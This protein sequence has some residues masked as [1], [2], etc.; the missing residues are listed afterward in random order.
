[1]N[2]DQVDTGTGRSRRNS[3]RSED[4]ADHGDVREDNFYAT[5]E[6]EAAALEGSSRGKNEND[7][8]QE[9]VVIGNVG[10]SSAEGA[11]GESPPSNVQQ[12]RIHSSS[13]SSGNSS[14]AVESSGG[15]EPFRDNNRNSVEEGAEDPSS[16]R[17]PSPFTA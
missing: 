16:R 4:H 11:G 9:P 12:F 8:L 3:E 1:M 5:G 6:R 2:A 14:D 13:S 17:S 7:D 15:E 10:R